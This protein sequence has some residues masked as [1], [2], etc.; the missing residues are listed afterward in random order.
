MRENGLFSPLFVG[1]GVAITFLGSNLNIFLKTKMH[2]LFDPLIPSFQRNGSTDA[3]EE[4]YKGSHCSSDY[5]RQGEGTGG[6]SVHQFRD[7]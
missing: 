3:L 4:I 1:M 2:T 5:K 7:N 6:L